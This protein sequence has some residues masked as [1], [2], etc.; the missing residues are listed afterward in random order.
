MMMVVAI[1]VAGA[2]E[3]TYKRENYPARQILFAGYDSMEGDVIKQ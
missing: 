2:V 1:H 3:F